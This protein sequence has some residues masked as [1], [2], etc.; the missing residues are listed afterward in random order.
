MFQSIEEALDW[1]YQQK[2]SK[3]RENLDRINFLI[4]TLDLRPKY[5]IIHIAGTNGKGSTT[6]YLN[7]LLILRN[8]RVGMFVSPYVIEFNERIEVNGKYISDADV[9]RLTNDLQRIALDYY[10]QT[11][12]TIPFFEL[13]FLMALLYFKEQQIEYLILECGLGGTLDAT[14]ALDKDVAVITNIGYDHMLQLGNTLEEIAQHKLGITRP[15]VPCF[16]TVAKALQPTFEAYAKKHQIPMHYVLEDISNVKVCGEGVAFS[17][18]NKEYMTSL[19]GIYQAQNASL[20]LAVIDYLDSRYPYDLARK[21]LKT[22]FW[23]GRFERFEENIILDG[24]HNLP[25]MEGL[26]DSLELIYPNYTIKVVF[27]A[28]KDKAIKEMLSV[29]DTITNQYYFTTFLDNRS[30]D[31]TMYLTDK[32]YQIYP[33][34]KEAIEVAIKELKPKEVLVI[35]GSLHFISEVRKI[36]N[37]KNR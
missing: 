1:L 27:T 19:G 9:L 24:A 6:S 34:Y 13:T 20:A 3:K 10:T 2:K 8:Y 35:T 11:K 37:T 12:D 31:P 33:D 25:G 28:L 30:S 4:D 26:R 29:L 17:Y 23:P 16:T 32:P 5:H 36:L 15:F 22:T 21:A 18:K 7:Q 14:N